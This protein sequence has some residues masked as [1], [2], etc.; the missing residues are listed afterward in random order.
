MS[1]PERYPNQPPSSNLYILCLTPFHSVKKVT[2]RVHE[3]HVRALV[4]ARLAARIVITLARIPHTG[5]SEDVRRNFNPRGGRVTTAQ[6]RQPN[7]KWGH[8]ALASKAFQ[9][10]EGGQLKNS[11]QRNYRR[12]YSASGRLLYE[13]PAS[14]LCPPNSFCC[15]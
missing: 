2:R 14:K 9:V 11:Q 4:A 6:S 12:N 8:E 5:I 13:Q 7:G 1:F 10:K 15:H 3:W